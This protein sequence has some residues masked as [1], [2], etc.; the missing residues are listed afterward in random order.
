MLVL[1]LLGGLGVLLLSGDDDPAAPAAGPASLEPAAE[2]APEGASSGRPAEPEGGQGDTDGD[3]ALSA[4]QLGERFGDAVFRV[5]VEGCGV[6][7]TGTAFAIADDLL[8]TNAHVVDVDPTP[9]LVARDGSS[10]E[11]TVIGLRDWPDLA[12]IEVAGPLDVWLE[13]APTEEL[14][15]GQSVT[16]LSYP[17]PLLTFSV[18]PG[19]LMSF[20]TEGGERIALASDEITDY[21]SSGGPLLD[22]RGRVAGV[23]TEFAAGDG[24]QVVGL[25]YTYAFLREDLE[26][27]VAAP[28]TV[29]PSCSGPGA[30]DLPDGW[31]DDGSYWD[32]GV[33]GYGTDPGLDA[34]WDACEAGDMQACDDLYRY[35]PVASGY[36]AFGDSCGERN[37]PA[38][39]CEDL[40][41]SAAPGPADVTGYGDDPVLDRLWDACEGGDMPAC[42]ELFVESPVGSSYERFG[43]S[44]GERNEPAGWC[45]DLYG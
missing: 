27:I 38:G 20:Q 37:E 32:P 23:V 4:Q 2:D 3:G 11:G 39:W 10:L 25:S 6:S 12:V 30:P 5:E 26:A 44:C 8:V 15:E 29:T 22:D 41:G 14:A 40:Y 45:E 24:R 9:R 16:A 13:W 19:T 33:D 42:D 35:S 17:T 18:A 43:D 21:G 34:L 36:E 1:A 28:S 7:G 31:L